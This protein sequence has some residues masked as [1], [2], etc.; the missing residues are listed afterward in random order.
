MSTIS[1]NVKS[2]NEAKAMESSYLNPSFT[3]EHAFRGVMATLCAIAIVSQLAPGCVRE[4]RQT[5][6][7]ASLHQLRR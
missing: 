4:E 7:A 3:L 5:R 2:I 6:D 1:E